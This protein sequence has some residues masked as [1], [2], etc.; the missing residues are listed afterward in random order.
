[1]VDVPPVD[2]PL[3]VN[4]RFLHHAEPHR[5]GP[6]LSKDAIA[7]TDDGSGGSKAYSRK[8]V[9]HELAHLVYSDEV[10]DDTGMEDRER[11]AIRE[12]WPDVM[13]AAYADL[14]AIDRGLWQRMDVPTDRAQLKQTG[15]RG[16]PAHAVASV[17]NVPAIEFGKSMAL[18]RWVRSGTGLSPNTY[19]TCRATRITALP[20]EQ[21]P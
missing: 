7:F 1:M 16:S 11:W 15:W 19:L 17:L 21:Q 3:L 4:Q 10:A 9:A 14:D 20:F 8:T 2:F 18:A 6:T 12:A 13:A 5:H